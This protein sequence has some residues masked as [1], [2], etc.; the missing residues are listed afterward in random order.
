MAEAATSSRSGER[1]FF[2]AALL[3]QRAA[4]QDA[5]LVLAAERTRSRLPGRKR[6]LP[7]GDREHVS[8]PV[9]EPFTIMLELG[10]SAS[11]AQPIAR[12]VAMSEPVAVAWAKPIA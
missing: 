5:R 11:V 3:R 10:A 9:A 12:R 2:A 6:D 8:E 1:R 4:E 7:R